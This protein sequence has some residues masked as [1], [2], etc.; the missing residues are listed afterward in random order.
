[1]SEALLEHAVLYITNVHFVGSRPVWPS[2]VS[3]EE[4]HDLILLP[5]QSVHATDKEQTAASHFANNSFKGKV[6]RL[7]CC[8]NLIFFLNHSK[9]LALKVLTS[10]PWDML[11]LLQLLLHVL[12]LPV[13]EK[14]LMSELFSSFSNFFHAKTTGFITTSTHLSLWTSFDDSNLACFSRFSLK[15]VISQAVV[16]W[17]CCLQQNPAQL[18]V[19]WVRE[20]PGRAL[21]QPGIQ[22]KIVWKQ[23]DP[24]WSPKYQ[25][26]SRLSTL[27]WNFILKGNADQTYWFNFHAAIY[28]WDLFDL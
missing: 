1:M 6:Q 12:D 7:Y 10:H 20:P 8:R 24:L 25:T 18:S 14:L 19:I 2:L 26:K 23:D 5:P 9:F 3:M 22:T 17:L 16:G 15:Q 28:M 27:L 11:S 4:L 21:L 13:F